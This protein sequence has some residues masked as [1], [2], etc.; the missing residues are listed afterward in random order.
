MEDYRIQLRKFQQELLESAELIESEAEEIR[1]ER[2]I[3]IWGN[4]NCIQCGACCADLYR[5]RYNSGQSKTPQCENF[6]IE[7]EKAYCLAHDKKRE[8]LCEKW[9]CGNNTIKHRLKYQGDKMLRKVALEIGTLPKSY[10][11]PKLFP[12]SKEQRTKD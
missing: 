12:R 1:I 4:H 11:I 8:N 10:C 3:G 2:G 7:Q 6:K 5:C 9:F